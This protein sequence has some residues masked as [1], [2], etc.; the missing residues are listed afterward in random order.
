[1]AATERI[2]Q[3]QEHMGATPAASPSE[4]PLASSQ[5]PQEVQEMKNPSDETFF[6][7]T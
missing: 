7:I 1:M 5:G 3:M 6:V 4:I 2:T